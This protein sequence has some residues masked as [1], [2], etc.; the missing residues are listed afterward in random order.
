MNLHAGLDDD[1]RQYRAD[2][3]IERHLERF[4]S[5]DRFCVGL[6]GVD[7]CVPS[8]NFVF[9]LA[10]RNRGLA[11]VSWR[12]LRDDYDSMVSR[13]AK[14]VIHEVGH[15][16]GLDHCL[17]RSCVMWFSNTLR[18]TDSKRMSFC[19]VCART[20]QSAGEAR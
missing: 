17:N 8:L 3:V 15:L 20:R 5:T 6:T 16:E 13:L 9:G 11:V 12:R 4:S 14:E 2:V 1:R 19:A 18:E 7:L 10:L